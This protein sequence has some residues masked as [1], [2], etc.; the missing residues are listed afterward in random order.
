MV[1]ARAPAVPQCLLA[2]NDQRAAKEFKL[3]SQTCAPEELEAAVNIGRLGWRPDELKAGGLRVSEQMELVGS[4]E[5]VRRGARHRPHLHVRALRRSPL[6]SVQAALLPDADTDVHMGKL[7][8]IIIAWRDAIPAASPSKQGRPSPPGGAAR[9]AGGEESKVPTLDSCFRLFTT[10]ERLGAEDAWYC[11]KCKEHQRAVKKMVG[12]AEV[13]RRAS[14]HG[15]TLAA[16]DIWK[17]PPVVVI[18]LKRFRFSF[19]RRE[20][21]TTLID[22]PRESVARPAAAAA[23]VSPRPRAR[24]RGLD[25]GRYL[26]GP[27]NASPAVYDLFAVSVRSRRTQ[28]AVRSAEPA[29]GR[30]TWDRWASAT[31]PPTARCST[32]GSAAS[33]SPSTTATSIRTAATSP[34]RTHVSARARTPSA[35]SPGVLGRG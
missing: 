19:S 8:R 31:T 22:F 30:T 7:G 12:S 3:S 10:E 24:R 28:R 32:R 25:L 21:I 35:G 9:G 16:Q 34:R 18:H 6:P 26:L 1:A 15:C 23:A 27:Q 33:G 14:G 2:M 4:E 11:G 13:A 17:L 29:A 20:K 5:A